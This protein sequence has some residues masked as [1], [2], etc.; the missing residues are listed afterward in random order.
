MAIKADGT[1]VAT[2]DE[3]GKIYFAV[4]LFQ[5]NLIIQTLHWHSD[6]VN[7]L[8]FIDGAPYLVSG[9]NEAVIVQWQLA[10]QDK[11]FVSRIGNA[12]TNL[13]V[14]ANHYAVL[15]ANNCL[16]VMRTDNNKSVLEAR[17]FVPNSSLDYHDKMLLASHGQTL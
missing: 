17:C 2:G 3:V 1:E 9:G 11:T 5:N 12:I 8:Q 7:A 16:K 13:S 6:Q 10:K 15:L 14:S 4:N